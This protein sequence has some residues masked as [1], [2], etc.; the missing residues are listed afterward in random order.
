MPTRAQLRFGIIGLPAREELL[1]KSFVRLLDNRSLHQWHYLPQMADLWVVAPGVQPPSHGTIASE[2][3]QVLTVGGSDENVSASLNLPLAP[4]NIEAALNQ[5]GSK[6]LSSRVVSDKPAIAQSYP[7]S[8]RLTRWPRAN[9]LGTKERMRMATL[10]L[11]KPL[12]ISQLADYSFFPISICE[13]FVHDLKA[14]G[15]VQIIQIQSVP[16]SPSGTT[17]AMHLPIGPMTATPPALS[18]L[19]ARIRNALALKKTQ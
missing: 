13:G 4:L 10:L 8:Y 12:T 1:F 14:T 9:M 18:G 5:L 7:V 15:L 11:G 17:T 6:I 19:F 2:R 16:T 3:R